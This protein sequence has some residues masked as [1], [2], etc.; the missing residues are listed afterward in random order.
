[1][2]GS[3]KL[4]AEVFV[5][6]AHA[7]FINEAKTVLKLMI[8]CPD[9]HGTVSFWY[10][11]FL[12]LNLSIIISVRVDQPMMAI[13]PANFL[14]SNDPESSKLQRYLIIWNVN[15]EYLRALFI[16]HF[17]WGMI[18]KERT[19]KP[20]YKVFPSF[21]ESSVQ[22]KWFWW[23]I[24]KI[25]WNQLWRK[26]ARSIFLRLSLSLAFELCLTALRKWENVATG[27][28]VKSQKGMN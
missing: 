3:S 21:F 13:Q 9:P 27:G 11:I 10:F 26:F 12:Y 5:D 24:L 19:Q 25:S 17:S 8:D 4:G 6:E 18:L 7:I 28:L 20:Y 14:V 16:W 2:D 22:R 1:M 23:T 15:L